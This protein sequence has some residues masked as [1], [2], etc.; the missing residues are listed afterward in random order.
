L[1]TCAPKIIEWIP[2]GMMIG[3]MRWATALPDAEGEALALLLGEID[4]DALAD[5]ERLGLV[6]LDGD[7]DRLTLALG[8][9][10]DETLLLGE[11]ERLIEA[12]G[13]TEVLALLDG[14][15]L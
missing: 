12:D 11:I 2:F 5:G 3:E 1:I 9:S 7:K 10:E 6:E 8:L 13:D 4:G 14:D 15:T